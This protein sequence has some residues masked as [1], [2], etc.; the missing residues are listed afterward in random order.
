ME[1]DDRD[2]LARR[3]MARW[4]DVIRSARQGLPQHVEATRQALAATRDVIRAVDRYYDPGGAR[5]LLNTLVEQTERHLARLD[6][7]QAAAPATPEPD[8]SEPAP[9]TAPAEPEAPQ[10][11]Q[12]AATEPDNPIIIEHNRTTTLVHRT[13]K[14]DLAVRKALSN[15]GFRWSSNIGDEGAWYLPRPWKYHTR[16]NRVSRL[17]RDL[18]RLGTTFVVQTTPPTPQTE[19]SPTV[20]APAAEAAVTA[21]PTETIQAD[22]P[23][24]VEEAAAGSRN[25]ETTPRTAELTDEQSTVLVSEPEQASDSVGITGQAEGAAADRGE[26]DAEARED[27]AE[28]QPLDEEGRDGSPTQGDLLDLA[29][30]PAAEVE[31]AGTPADLPDDDQQPAPGEPE[32]EGTGPQADAPAAADAAQEGAPAA[33][34]P[35]PE[36]ARTIQE[37]LELLPGEEYLGY[38]GRFDGDYD[39]S[40][41][42]GRYVFRMPNMDRMRYSVRFMPDTNRGWETERI[43]TTDD[44]TGVMPLVRQH[45]RRLA[46]PAAYE[47]NTLRTAEQPAQQ[48]EMNTA[49]QEEPDASAKPQQAADS[50]GITTDEETGGRGEADRQLRSD[51]L[52]VQPLGEEERDNGPEQGGLF[53]VAEPVAA[54]PG[55][56]EELAAL[57]DDDQQPT[58]TEPETEDSPQVDLPAAET[59]Q[60]GTPGTVRA[61]EPERTSDSVGITAGE[62]QTAEEPPGPLTDDDIR[63]ALRTQVSGWKLANLVRA[64]DDP[65]SLRTWMQQQAKS[66]RSGYVGNRRDDAPGAPAHDQIDE[67]RRGI[68]HRVATPDGRREGTITWKQAAERVRAVMTP[69]LAR[70][71]IEVYDATRAQS[72]AGDLDTESSVQLGR[73][74]REASEAI[75]DAIDAAGPPSHRRAGRSSRQRSGQPEPEQGDLFAPEGAPEPSPSREDATTP[76]QAPDQDASEPQEPGPAADSIG[77]DPEPPAIPAPAEPELSGT[78]GEEAEEVEH[79]LDGNPDAE[80]DEEEDYEL[81]Y[82]EEFELT[83]PEPPTGTAAPLTETDIAF[84]VRNYLDPWGVVE[85]TAGALG[86]P[87]TMERW[88]ERGTRHSGGSANVLPEGHPDAGSSVSMGMRRNGLYAH[89]FAANGSRKG[90]IPWADILGGVREAL[91]TERVNV[92]F[93]AENAHRALWDDWKFA[94]DDPEGWESQNRQVEQELIAA[95]RMILD[96]LRMPKPGSRPP[97][98][99]V[100]PAQAEPTLFEIDEVQP[101]EGTIALRPRSEPRYK[102]PAEVEA[103]DMLIH[104][105][106]AGGPFIVREIAHRGGSTVLTGEVYY[107][108]RPPFREPWSTDATMVI[109]DDLD[110]RMELAP[111]RLDQASAQEPEPEAE[112]QQ[113][114]ILTQETGV[115]V[116]VE[117]SPAPE[118]QPVQEPAQEAAASASS[119]PVSTAIDVASTTPSPEE[120]TTPP[121]PA[122]A[123]DSVGIASAQ[124]EAVPSREG[125]PVAE[126]PQQLALAVPVA[127]VLPQID[128]PT[129]EAAIARADAAV[130]ALRTL[131]RIGPGALGFPDDLNDAIRAAWQ[132]AGQQATARADEQRR[133]LADA[134]QAVQAEAENAAAP[135]FQEPELPAEAEQGTAADAQPGSD[136]SR[137]AAYLAD[138]RAGRPPR[139]EAAAEAY[140]EWRQLDAEDQEAALEALDL[141]NEYERYQ[142]P[143][144]WSEWL[145]Q[146]DDP[147]FDATEEPS[148]EESPQQSA[149]ALAERGEEDR[150]E[151]TSDGVPRSDSSPETAQEQEAGSESDEPQPVV[152]PEPAVTAEDERAET[153]QTPVEATADAPERDDQQQDAG[154]D[155]EGEGTVTDQQEAA[156]AGADERDRAE[157]FFG[158]VNAVIDQLRADLDDALAEEPAEQNGQGDPLAAFTDALAQLGVEVDPPGT[159]PPAPDL[160]LDGLTEVE[161]AYTAASRHAREYNGAPEWRQLNQLWQST[162]RVWANA[163]EVLARYGADLATDIRW[164]GMLRT[165]GIRAAEGVARLSNRL[166]ERLSGAGRNNSPGHRALQGLSRAAQN[167]A[168]RLRG[169][170]PTER[171][172][173]FDSLA[174]SIR[175][176]R[177]DLTRGP[178]QPQTQTQAEGATAPG[179]PTATRPQDFDAFRLVGEAF[180]GAGRHA[181]EYNGAPEWRRLTTVWP[182][183]TR[184]L[185]EHRAAAVARYGAD[186]ATDIRWRGIER[187]AAIRSLDTVA[188]LSNRLA[189]RLSNAGRHDSPGYRAIQALGHAAQRAASALRGE[190][191]TERA[192]RVAAFDR[193]TESIRDLRADLAQVSLDDDGPDRG[194]DGP[195][196]GGIPFGEPARPT[197][198]TNG[199][200]ADQQ[201][202]NGP[203]PGGNAPATR[204]ALTGTRPNG[205]GL[206]E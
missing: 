124:G 117:D 132:Q 19:L 126:E 165:V 144:S 80:Y 36:Q 201:A 49:A 42:G 206:G 146:R 142:G 14:E 170:N 199:Q 185:G 71:L 6:A 125:T 182:T 136:E 54:E 85:A 200:T 77:I 98:S 103:G 63:V 95:A 183:A 197:L 194:G 122:E 177:A 44:L 159:E 156:I 28:P 16:D 43:G 25:E 150:Q 153:T 175:D 128:E 10:E 162:Q 205:P 34:E 127:P 204:P 174:E 161:Q 89:V 101:L 130:D 11:E 27:A 48:T 30:P 179:Q 137:N 181:R 129:Y 78:E 83:A 196:P 195:G 67:T 143:L 56:A 72:R 17:R 82:P 107:I 52:E 193:L 118:P 145:Q 92:L 47:E 84:A 76:A 102:A 97:R 68:R 133:E 157:D 41:P 13:R 184:V 189:E 58:P 100:R 74:L 79:G 51:E 115:Q 166:A 110:E 123:S 155:P 119:E 39:L 167:F 65:D 114:I 90:T 35:E 8:V 4:G 172:A 138:Y 15:N 178:D 180:D 53:A 191:P 109:G 18:E 168:A 139:D 121:E 38:A 134:F 46:E 21:E 45:A 140:R 187:T 141:E 164:H 75:H 87:V 64:L 37:S 131:W 29:E 171:F 173:A 5:R 24:T 188:R 60:E 160:G 154:D 73:Q 96:A 93:A 192:E 148:P 169:H 105:G 135:A 86:D 70:A 149:N 186:L 57:L 22:Q 32:N 104:H 202:E 26:V 9:A 151:P 108:G 99:A 23:P 59:A 62:P 198:Q 50:V 7:T 88:V 55:E 66:A 61:P 152:E 120:S 69:D 40:I 2:G 158:Q 31:D 91:T 112:R 176:L 12:H 81:L 203:G 3:F 111:A 106:Y 147:E 190:D 33:A 116:A 113:E 20:P 1:I 94:I 163:R